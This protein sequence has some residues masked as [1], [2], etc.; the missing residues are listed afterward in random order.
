MELIHLPP[1]S[2]TS[3]FLPVILCLQ[4]HTHFPGPSVATGEVC[5]S[6]A[7]LLIEH[8]FRHGAGSVACGRAAGRVPA[9]ETLCHIVYLE[10]SC[11]LVFRHIS[12]L[13]RHHCTFTV[14]VALCVRKCVVVCRRGLSLAA[15]E[16]Q[17][18]PSGLEVISDLGAQGD[19]F[20]IMNEQQ[21]QQ[22]PNRQSYSFQII[23]THLF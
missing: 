19:R 2:P 7:A 9:S 12:C 6:G 8:L 10:M 13:H 17:L 15:V 5:G 21:Q 3:G 14:I 23:T 16:Q 20:G 1:V 22:Q 18:Q 11:S 4:T